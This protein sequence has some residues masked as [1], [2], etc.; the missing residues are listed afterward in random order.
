MAITIIIP[1]SFIASIKDKKEFLGL[2]KAFV[3]K[4]AR[5]YFNEHQKDYKLLEEKAWNH[6]NSTYKLSIKGIRALLRE[7]HGVFV[8]EGPE[9]RTALLEEFKHAQGRGAQLKVL[10][11]LL[12]CHQS[13]KERKEYY[14]A[15]YH[16]IRHRCEDINWILDIGC[17]MNPLAYQWL[18]KNV[19]YTA[20]DISQGEMDIINEFFNIKAIRGEAF[21]LD[22]LERTKRREQFKDIQADTVFMFKVIDTLESQQRNVSKEII[23]ELFDKESLKQ[24]I[25]SFP[26]VSLGGKKMR[27]GGKE[28][29]FSRYLDE[30]NYAYELFTEGGEEF[31]VIRQ[32]S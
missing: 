29:W 32:N 14:P 4:K 3:N 25:V 2:D 17:G 5:S 21:A 16:K 1:E 24:I 20:C 11:K 23:D 13:T 18:G 15:I 12:A 9:K 26:L 31:W 8:L 19:H 27:E 22:V 6:R 10:D 30:K 28:N 7:I